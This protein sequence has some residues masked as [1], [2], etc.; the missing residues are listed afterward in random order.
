MTVSWYEHTIDSYKHPYRVVNATSVTPRAQ[1]TSAGM[2]IEYKE[3]ERNTMKTPSFVE[4]Y[5][6]I[7][8]LRGHV[9]FLSSAVPVTC[10]N[11]VVI[12]FSYC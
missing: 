1:Q 5:P 6:Q 9:F 4:F 8:F 2:C 12:I 11:I 7:D 10:P 3:Q